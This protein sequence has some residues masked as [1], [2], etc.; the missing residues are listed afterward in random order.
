MKSWWFGTDRRQRKLREK[1]CPRVTLSP[2]IPHGLAWETNPGPRGDSLLLYH[3]TAG[4][5]H[6]LETLN[7]TA[8]QP[9]MPEVSITACSSLYSPMVPHS[10]HYMYHQV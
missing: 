6:Y 4:V 5:L 10:G 1:T 3:D 2:Q 8:P 9:D 7:I